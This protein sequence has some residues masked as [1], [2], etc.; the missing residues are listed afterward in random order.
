MNN[1]IFVASTLQTLLSEGTA[2]FMPIGV[3][4]CGGKD[5]VFNTV[6]ASFRGFIFRI[7]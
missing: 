3:G 7:I 6:K 2:V 1:R 4:F 5:T